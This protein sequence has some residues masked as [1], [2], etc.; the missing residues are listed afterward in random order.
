MKIFL[1][2][3][4]ARNGKDTV[5]NFIVDYFNRN[6][7]KIVKTAYAKYIKLFTRELTDWN[8]QE[9]TKSLYRD[10]FQNLGTQVIRQKMNKPDFFVKRMVEDLEIYQNYVDAVVISDVRFPI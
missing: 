10:F 3:G 7:K 5:S 2:S 1:I 4:K 9:E 8:G 6:N